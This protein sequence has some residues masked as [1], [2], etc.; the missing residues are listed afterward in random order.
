MLKKT[1][2]GVLSRSAQ[3]YAPGLSPSGLG[4]RPFWAACCFNDDHPGLRKSS[5]AETQNGF[6]QTC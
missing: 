3:E 5:S 2:S 6:P 4:W 1:T